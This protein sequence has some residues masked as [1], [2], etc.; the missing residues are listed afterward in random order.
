MIGEPVASNPAMVSRT[1]RSYSGLSLRSFR[2][3]SATA[4]IS[5][6]GLG[7]L[8][9]GS[10]GIFNYVPLTTQRVANL[11]FLSSKCTLEINSTFSAQ[12]AS[13]RFGFVARAVGESCAIV[14]QFVNE[15]AAED[16][17]RQF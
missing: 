2:S 4:S 14:S 5:H 6:E 8:P 7:M 3:P 15:T 13:L 16:C 9:I 11:T 17:N 10:V 12:R 1:A